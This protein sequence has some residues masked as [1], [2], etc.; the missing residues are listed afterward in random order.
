MW[1]YPPARPLPWPLSGSSFS[2]WPSSCLSSSSPRGWPRYGALYDPAS[3]FGHSR[4]S[5]LLKNAHLRRCPRPSSLRR[6]SMYVSL[7]RISGALHLGIFEQP[8]ENKFLNKLL[9]SVRNLNDSNPRKEKHDEKVGLEE[10]LLSCS[11]CYPFR[12]M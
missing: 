3:G 1:G 10:G 4:I 5:R 12:S 11:G 8:A 2:V 9:K 6:T 7:L